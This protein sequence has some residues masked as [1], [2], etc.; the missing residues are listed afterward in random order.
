MRKIIII[1]V[2]AITIIALC[3][4]WFVLPVLKGRELYMS[5]LHDK[6]G[7]APTILTEDYHFYL[8]IRNHGY[9]GVTWNVDAGTY[10]SYQ[11]TTIGSI[12]AIDGEAYTMK[13]R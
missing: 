7:T 13:K 4:F 8:D 12:M 11:F 6:F 9:M 1:A 10:G 3:L 5:Y 2:T